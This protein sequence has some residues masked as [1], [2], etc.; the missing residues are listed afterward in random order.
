MSNRGVRSSRLDFKRIEALAP[1]GASV[2]DLGC[3][4]GQLMVELCE[5]RGCSVH[6]IDLDERAVRSCIQWG[7]PVFHGDMLEGMSFFPD[8]SFD[9]VILSQTLQQVSRPAAVIREMLR[10]GRRAA[11]SFPHLGYWKTRLALLGGRAPARYGLGPETDN[12]APNIRLCTLRDFRG[13]CSG[14][15]VTIEDEILLTP[16]GREI[17]GPLAAWRADVAIF[18]LSRRGASSL[19]HN[20]TCQ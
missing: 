5:T 3:G 15:D 14:E 11:V 13:L 8:G 17:R 16:A 2:L 19:T 4:D 10:L 20:I 18:V 6:G 9:L 7:V 1:Q 12:A